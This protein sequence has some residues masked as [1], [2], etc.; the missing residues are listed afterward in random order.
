M[1]QLSYDTDYIGSL[2]WALQK[3]QILYPSFQVGCALCQVVTM[4]LVLPNVKE[5]E[6]TQSSNLFTRH[7]DFVFVPV[8]RVTRF[9]TNLS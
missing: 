6:E 8:A 7:V 4:Y 1:L 5:P 3:H 2:P 9:Y